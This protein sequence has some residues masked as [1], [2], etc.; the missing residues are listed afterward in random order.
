MRECKNCKNQVS[1]K[2]CS[3]FYMECP[4]C[5]AIT[6]LYEPQPHQILFHK[7]PS[8]IKAILGRFR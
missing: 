8:P 4:Y 3:Q 2:H 1:D 5:N 6:Q 7:D